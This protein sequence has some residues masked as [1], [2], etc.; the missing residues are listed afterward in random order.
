MKIKNVQKDTLV[1]FV[2]AVNKAREEL[3]KPQGAKV[4]HQQVSSADELL[5][6][7]SLLDQG[8]ITQEEFNKKK[9][10]LLGL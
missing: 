7:K 5:K 8:V 2:N 4:F 9:K 3:R 10:E 1:P 6:F